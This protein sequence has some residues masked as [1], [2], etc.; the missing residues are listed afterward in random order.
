MRALE[1]STP[2]CAF[3]KCFRTFFREQHKRLRLGVSLTTS[4]S[5]VSEKMFSKLLEMFFKILA[6][7]KSVFYPHIKMEISGCQFESCVFKNCL[8]FVN[9]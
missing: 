8:P 2:N 3:T 1:V 5:K 9:L 7:L 4:S 6:W